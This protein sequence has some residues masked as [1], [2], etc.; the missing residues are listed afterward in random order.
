MAIWR[1]TPDPGHLDHP[2]WAR[3][4]NKEPVSVIASDEKDARK[5]AMALDG[6][7]CMVPLPKH[8]TVEVCYKEHTAAL[9]N[10]Y[11]PGC[12]QTDA[13]TVRF[14]ADDFMEVLRFFHF[15]L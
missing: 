11:Y 4:R 2:F 7:K 12:V 8:F 15:C 5:K 14:E 6:G 9:S 1:L 3:R 10:S 13:R